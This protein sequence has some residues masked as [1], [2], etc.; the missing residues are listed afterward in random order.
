MKTRNFSFFARVLLVMIVAAAL[1]APAALAKDTPRS[2]SALNKDLRTTKQEY[3]KFQG[4]ESKLHSA[5]NQSSNTARETAVH[6]LQDF[7]GECI[8]RREGDLSEIMTLKQHG[9]NVKSGTTDV[10]EVGAPVP[11]KKSAKGSAVYSTTSGD[12]LRQLSGMKSLYISAKNNS[13]P[14]IEKQTGAFERYE[15]TIGKF[16]QQL[17]WGVDAMTL[18]MEHREALAE[19]KK[20]DSEGH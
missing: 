15:E 14:A 20:A 13:R 1:A 19:K 18:E 10:A 3:K 2:D 9:K 8:R 5:A 4:L 11:G 6:N 17:S 7:M 16:G 12:R